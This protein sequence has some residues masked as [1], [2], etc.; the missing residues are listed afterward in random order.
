ME[1]IQINLTSKKYPGLKIKVDKEDY[2]LVKDYKWHPSKARSQ[3]RDLFYALADIY[4]NGIRTT[5]SMHRLILKAKGGT[6]IDH[7]NG[8]GLDNRKSNLRFVTQRVNTQNKHVKNSSN[9]PGVGWSKANNKWRAR[10]MDSEGVTFHLGTYDDEEEAYQAYLWGLSELEAGR[11]IPS[12]REM[13]K[14]SRYK[15]VNWKTKVGKWVAEL[16]VKGKY[17]YLGC[18]DTEEDAHEAV[19]KFRGQI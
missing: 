19:V 15:N 8:D 3:R 12:L 13:R 2:P 10:V 6:V 18:F 9:Y 5:I 11:S 14:T 1:V 4:R 16:T 17:Y 7:I